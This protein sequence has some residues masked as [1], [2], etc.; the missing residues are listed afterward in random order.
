M[1][2]EIGDATTVTVP[3]VNT[4][5]PGYAI[6]INAAI[7]ELQARVAQRADNGSIA[8]M[9]AGTVKANLTGALADAQDVTLAALSAALGGGGG[10]YPVIVEDIGVSTA[11]SGAA[12]ELALRTHM[13]ASRTTP[14]TYQFG[15]GTYHFDKNALAGDPG[16]GSIYVQNMAAR[17]FVGM[18]VGVTFLTYGGLGNSG[19]WSFFY[20]AGEGSERFEVRDLTLACTDITNRDGGDQHHLIDVECI[21]AHGTSK[22]RSNIVVQNVH[23]DACIGSGFRT[24]GEP[25]IGNYVENYILFNVTADGSGIAPGS[26]SCYEVQ[27]GSRLGAYV[28]VSGVGA[29]NSVFDSEITSGGPASNLLFIN[30]FFDGSKA[31]ASS[32]TFS[33]GGS[34]APGQYRSIDWT[35][36]NVRVKGGYTGM[37]YGQRIRLYDCLFEYTPGDNVT[38]DATMNA[39]GG[40][41]PIFTLRGENDDIEFTN[42]TFRRGIGVIKPGSL[43]DMQSLDAVQRTHGVRLTNPQFIEKSDIGNGLAVYASDVQNLSITDLEY[44]HA[45]TSTFDTAAS[46]VVWR[47]TNCA[48]SDSL[49]ID[50]LSMTSAGGKIRQLVS[51]TAGNGTTLGPVTLLGIDSGSVLNAANNSSCIVVFDQGGTGIVHENPVIQGCRSNGQ[52]TWIAANATATKV[53]PVVAGNLGARATKTLES[54]SVAPN[55]Y[56]LGAPGDLFLYRATVQT[57]ELWIKKTQTS[58]AILTQDR[59]GWALMSSSTAASVLTSGTAT[60]SVSRTSDYHAITVTVTDA[61][62]TATSKIVGVSWA[63][64]ETDENTP[65]TCHVE[66]I[67]GTPGV[68]SFPITLVSRDGKPVGGDYKISYQ[69]AN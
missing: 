41:N 51:V 64:V 53:F 35:L 11:N 21:T 50:G 12:N 37:Y 67:P 3:A 39:A 7:Q 66:F 60:L 45:S 22:I 17:R 48:N 6:T 69:V 63:A 68:G 38:I 42:C 40:A 18:G 46:V 32:N 28:N 4:P 47:G 13:T 23:L 54:Y 44:Q 58:S 55:T 14:Y 56:A 2:N 20:V 5:G 34:S 24:V 59:N 49:R 62:V 31:A 33:I 36:S 26:R 19:Q 9:P 65:E 25:T 1:A 61:T 27:R 10:G 57:F 16:R 29:K 8:Q 43:L 30:C 52:V 15:P